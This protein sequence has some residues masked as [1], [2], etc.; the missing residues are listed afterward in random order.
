MYTEYTRP[1]ENNIQHIETPHN[2][3]HTISERINAEVYTEY[4]RPVENNIQHTIS[5]RINTNYIEYTTPRN[6]YNT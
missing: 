3:Q 5:E 2:I 4:T 1:V 6:I